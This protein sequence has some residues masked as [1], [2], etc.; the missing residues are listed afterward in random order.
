MDTPSEKKVYTLFLPLLEMIRVFERTA[1]IALPPEDSRLKLN[2]VVSKI[3][4]FYEKLRNA[5]DYAEEHLLRE[6]AVYRNLKRTMTVTNR[7]G[8]AIAKP[9]IYDL[10]R[11][12]YLPNDQ[13]HEN[14]ISQVEVIIN[15]YII[16]NNYI[17]NYKVKDEKVDI[18]D[19]LLSMLAIEIDDL[20]VSKDRDNA[21]VECMY[22]VVKKDV[23]VTDN[24]YSELDKKIQMYI[25]ILKSLMKADRARVSFYLWL[26]YI[27][28]WSTAGES[29]LLKIAQNISD[30]YTNITKQLDHPLQGLYIKILRKYNV[31]FLLIRDIIWEYPMQAVDIWKQ[32]QLL[33]E[34]IRQAAKK[35]YK[36]SRVKLTR[37]IIRSI[38]Y[39][40][41]TK[42]ILAVLLEFP[43]DLMFENT[44]NYMTIAINVTF[45]PLLM[46][47]IGL[48]IRVPGIKNTD[49]IVQGIKEISYQFDERNVIRKIKKPLKRS[50][51]LTRVFKFI[52]A[53]IFLFTFALILSGLNLLGFNIASMII[54]IF[55]LS[56]VSFFSIRISQSAREL[57]ILEKKDN[58]LTFITDF[59]SLP[60]LEA[61][62]WLS[63]KL[64]MINFF[65]VFFDF[66][67][68]AP[69]K[70]LIEAIDEWTG[71]VREKKEEIY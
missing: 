66:I 4:F 51:L 22:Q 49:K 44:I 27:P 47:I 41:I 70:V 68:E 9:L 2:T 26:M 60:I 23:V 37:S 6:R 19:L 30:L 33:E 15:R 45:P 71:Y 18:F 29:E 5:V 1:Q 8:A 35:R 3:S 32:P 31:L 25:A 50:V 16:L 43:L 58:A 59:F 64:N 11:S 34:R 54:F 10:I 14:V 28:E 57:H 40:F 13:L 56:L 53:I 65:V 46:F 20:L 69:F 7:S 17:G 24:R 12:G 21:L 55:F 42:M 38:I 48:F 67:I 36:V 39:L 61:G 62:R 63:N 52:Y